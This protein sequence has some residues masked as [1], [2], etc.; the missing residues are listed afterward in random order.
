MIHYNNIYEGKT[1]LVT[2]HT[3]FKG[4]WLT[5]WLKLLGA[6]VVGISLEPSTK[7]SHFSAIHAGNGIVDLRLDIRDSKALEDSILSIK[8]DFIFITIHTFSHYTSFSII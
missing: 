5:V 2:G 7:P 6:N 4:S 3:G 8:P 1:V